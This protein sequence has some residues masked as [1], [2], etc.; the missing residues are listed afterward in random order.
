MAGQSSLANADLLENGHITSSDLIQ[1]HTNI[2]RLYFVNTNPHNTNPC[3]IPYYV[4]LLRP[5]DALLSSVLLLPGHT[6]LNHPT[7]KQNPTKQRIQFPTIQTCP[8]YPDSTFPPKDGTTCSSEEI[9][10][11]QCDT[12]SQEY[13]DLLIFSFAYSCMNRRRCCPCGAPISPL[14]V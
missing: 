10:A 11:T 9:M 12:M 14:R 2:T 8:G 1:T 7:Q 4:P 6:Q 5:P 3:T 13:T